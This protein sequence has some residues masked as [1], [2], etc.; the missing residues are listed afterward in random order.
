MHPAHPAPLPL[1]SNKK[2]PGF[3]SSP[4][5]PLFSLLISGSRLSGSMLQEAAK[6]GVSS[7]LGTAAPG[8]DGV[9]GC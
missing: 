7:W 1:K 2:I 5:R 3:G 9:G 6:T 4:L 8:V